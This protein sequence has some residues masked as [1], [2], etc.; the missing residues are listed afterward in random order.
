MPDRLTDYQ[1]TL[2]CQ[3]THFYENAL[4]YQFRYITPDWIN[5]VNSLLYW[6]R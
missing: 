4:S 2:S 3:H 5:M 1:H 6:T